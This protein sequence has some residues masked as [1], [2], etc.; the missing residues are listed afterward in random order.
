MSTP[1]SEPEPT[2]RPKKG[3]TVEEESTISDEQIRELKNA[4]TSN[5]NFS[6][7]VYLQRGGAE[8]Q[9]C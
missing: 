8:R 4:A 7:K 6:V 5:V 9:K 2:P 1:T 3:A